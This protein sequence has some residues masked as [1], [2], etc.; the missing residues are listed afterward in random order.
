MGEDLICLG[1]TE[2]QRTGPVHRREAGRARSGAGLPK[3]VFQ[4]LHGDKEAVDAI[5][6]HSS[7]KVVGFVGSSDIAQTSTRPPPPRVSVH[8]ASAEPRIT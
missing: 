3:G 5:V 8:S 4:V 1:Y 7:I 2:P 6:N